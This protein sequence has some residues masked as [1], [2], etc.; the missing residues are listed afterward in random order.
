ME[1]DLLLLKR[2][3]CLKLRIL[4]KTVFKFSVLE[5]DILLKIVESYFKDGAK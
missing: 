1:A 5:G 2:W 3:N 4:F